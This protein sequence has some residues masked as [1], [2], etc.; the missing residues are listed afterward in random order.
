MYKKFWFSHESSYTQAY[1]HFTCKNSDSQYSNVLYHAHLV[2]SKVLLL[3]I[4]ISG[5]PKL[6]CFLFKIYETICTVYP[7]DVVTHNME[8]IDYTEILFASNFCSISGSFYNEINCNAL[9]K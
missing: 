7:I 9:Q 4:L 2:P 1:V 5:S 8:Q 3:L 6:F